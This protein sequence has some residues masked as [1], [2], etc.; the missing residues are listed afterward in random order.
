MLSSSQFNKTMDFM[1]TYK[2]ALSCVEQ[3]ADR[4]QSMAHYE[5]T[6]EALVN[7]MGSNQVA[8]NN[9]RIEGGANKAD[10]V[11]VRAHQNA[12]D[13][14]QTYKLGM[15]GSRDEFVKNLNNATSTMSE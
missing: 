15:A 9:G 5:N 3:I 1:A 10:F 12:K 6:T 2:D 13:V 11:F 8:V 4:R 14:F 7:G